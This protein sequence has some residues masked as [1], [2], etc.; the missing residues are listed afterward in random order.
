MQKISSKFQLFLHKIPLCFLEHVDVS[1]CQIG[2]RLKGSLGGECKVAAPWAAP[3]VLA[4][5]SPP[6]AAPSMLANHSP[7]LLVMLAMAFKRPAHLP[8]A[9]G[10]VFPPLVVAKIFGDGIFR[11]PR[12]PWTYAAFPSG[13]SCRCS[14]GLGC[15]LP[16]QSG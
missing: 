6:W 1:S 13:T 2:F 10:I 9:G 16:M 3:S 15:G 14:R 11:L 5:H 4:N 7:L 12:V 8:Q